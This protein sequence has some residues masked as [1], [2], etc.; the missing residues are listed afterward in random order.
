MVEFINVTK[1]YPNGTIALR[2]L[3]LFI[4]R[5]EFVFIVGLSGAGKTTMVK[6]LLKEED[7]TEG[8]VILNG[9]RLSEVSLRETPYIRRGVGIV[10]QD[11]RLL[12]RKTVYENVAFAME[13]AAASPREIRR[14]VPAALLMVGLTRKADVYPAELSGG[15]QQRVA[16][17]RALINDPPVLI[18]DEPTGNL[19]PGTS[20][21]IMNLLEEINGRGTTVI[22]ATHERAVVDQM[23]KRVVEIQGGAIVRD[24]R[25]GLYEDE[26]AHGK[27]YF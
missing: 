19:D 24:Q 11:F 1:V 26:A 27:L 12:P 16:L 17:A 14:R 7:V 3:D 22:V 5:G 10:F 9:A 2:G 21:D 15:E 18:A 20:M 6:L 23:R 13:I 25:E 8:A 4:G